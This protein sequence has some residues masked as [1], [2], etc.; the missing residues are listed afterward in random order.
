[1]IAR[2]LLRVVSWSVMGYLILPL[3]VIVGSSFTATSYLA[4]PPQGLTLDW[5]GRMLGDTSYLAAFG[6]STLLALVATAA[7]LLL[8]VPA[9]LAIARCEFPG[10]RFLLSLLMSP[11]VLPHVVLGAA[12]LQYCAALGLM[13]SFTALLVGHIVIIM[14]FVLRSVLPQLTPEQRALEEA[15]ADL[16]ARPME[17]FFLVTLPQIRSGLASGAIFAFISSWINV[18]L[19]IFNTTAEMT[20]IPVKLFNYV[21]YTIDPVI[22]AV[23]S[24]TIGVAALAIIILDLTVGLHLLSDRR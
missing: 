23:S 18:E 20:T 12:L 5:Y 19:S 14:P 6:T 4:F 13:R 2:L 21:Q 22:A 17:T 24:I 3:L 8:G 9:A 15:S 16:G 10:K 1:M 11:L 7:A